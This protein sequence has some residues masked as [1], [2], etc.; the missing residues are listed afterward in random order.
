MK[1]EIQAG[2]I[3]TKKRRWHSRQAVWLAGALVWLA[4]AAPACAESPPAGE[5]CLF[6]TGRRRSGREF[7]RTGRRAR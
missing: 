4:G 2:L 3:K 6:R 7:A 5:R 1:D